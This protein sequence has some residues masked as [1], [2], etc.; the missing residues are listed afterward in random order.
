MLFQIIENEVREIKERKG[1]KKV[2]RSKVSSSYRYVKRFEKLKEERS[3]HKARREVKV[4]DLYLDMESIDSC[5][6]VWN[7]ALNK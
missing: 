1:K 7:R 2:Q 4:R 6:Y 3:G 5:D